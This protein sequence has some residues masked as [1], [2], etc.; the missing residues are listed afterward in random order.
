VQSQTT[1]LKPNAVQ[2]FILSILQKASLVTRRWTVLRTALPVLLIVGLGVIMGLVFASPSGTTIFSLL[3][4]GVCILI[5]LINPRSGFLLWLLV[6][7]LVV[8]L[9]LNIDLGGGIPDL[10]LGRL[11]VALVLVILLAEAAIGKRELPRLTRLDAWI[12]LT[13]LTLGIAALEGNDLVSDIQNFFDLYVMPFLVYYA[14]KNLVTDRR[15][16][17][18]F[19]VTAIALGTYCGIYGIY[20]QLTG[21]ILF[22]SRE[23]HHTYYTASLRI[24]RGLL[25]SPH[26]FG[27]VFSLVIPVN[28]YK[29]I[30]EKEMWKKQLYSLTLAVMIGALFLTY[31]RGAWLGTMI[32]FVVIQKFYP[33]FRRLFLALLIVALVV[34]GLTWE[35]VSE[36]EVVNQ[37]LGENLDT[38]NGRL[39][40]WAEAI[41]LWEA[42]PIF[43]YGWN[44]FRRASAKFI[45]VES[46]Y[47]WVLVSAGLL[48]FLPLVMVLVSVLREA[49]DLGRLGGPWSFVEPE[50]AAILGGLFVAYLV[51]IVTVKMNNTEAL[52][53]TWALVGAIIGSQGDGLIDAR[54]AHK[55]QAAKERTGST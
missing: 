53:L 31:K 39:D 43:G 37:R 38:G 16:L 2:A 3:N 29:L 36:S 24:M 10:S 21:N 48:G 32:S 34:V 13:M 20:T 55:A 44:G 7:P 15:S 22:T 9:N 49:V 52:A 12:I 41:D 11:T 5:T 50:L 33:Q 51:N 14:A 42:K 4:V 6:S 25:D 26:A 27:L 8:S 54:R 28:F 45:A 46:D 17:D 23:F 19:L 30:A 18:R 47:L 1:E 40:I 35:Q